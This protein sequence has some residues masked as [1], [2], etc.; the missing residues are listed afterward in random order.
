[1]K[2]RLVK[3]GQ[4]I[5]IIDLE[6]EQVPDTTIFDANNLWNVLNAMNTMCILQRWT[7]LRIGDGLYSKNCDKLAIIS[8]DTTDGTHNLSLGAFCNE[9]LNRARYGIPGTPNCF[10]NFVAAMSP[11]G[12]PAEDIDWNSCIN[13]CMDVRHLPD[14]RL[15][16]YPCHNKPGDYFDLMAQMDIIIAISNCPQERNA[17]NNYNP[18]AMM[19]VIFNPNEEYKARLKS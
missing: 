12:L 11:Y 6:G 14:G 17:C 10:D 5:R 19:A 16:Y 2:G 15:E 7:K 4:V 8:D 3:K 9:P 1:M 13:F 18:T